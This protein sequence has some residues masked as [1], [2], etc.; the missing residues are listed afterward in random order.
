MSTCYKIPFGDAVS[1][2]FLGLADEQVVHWY[3]LVHISH[4]NL[5]FSQ[6]LPLVETVVPST[7]LP[8][9]QDVEQPT[10]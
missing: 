10:V 6:V 5:Q 3:I 4:P 1:E 8:V 2:Y 7:Y 9:G